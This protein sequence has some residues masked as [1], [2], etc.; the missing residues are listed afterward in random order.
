MTLPALL[1][2]FCCPLY[3]FCCPAFGAVDGFPKLLAWAEVLDQIRDRP[4]TTVSAKLCHRELLGVN[5]LLK[6]HYHAEQL[7]SLVRHLAFAKIAGVAV[8]VVRVSVLSHRSSARPAA[9]NRRHALSRPSP[10]PSHDAMLAA[11]LLPGTDLI[12]LPGVASRA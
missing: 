9:H 1:Y 11:T 12:R 4:L 10:Q 6:I 5:G 8:G 3:M 7:R 2:L